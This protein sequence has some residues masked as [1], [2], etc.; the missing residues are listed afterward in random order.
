MTLASPTVLLVVE[1][2][3]DV[4]L[5]VQVTL[6]RDPRIEINGDASTAEQAINL[7]REHSPGLIILDHMLEGDI[8]G[9]EAA[10]RLKEAAPQAKILMF[11]A[12]DLES[13]ARAVPAVDA[14][15]LK[16]QFDK[17]LPT[18]QRLLGLE[19]VA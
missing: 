11:S 12:L 2:D 5:L 8:D 10:P 17:L 1:D 4:R 3:P 7:C 6:G 15:L 14:F 9:L 13:R 18:C 19:P 16:T